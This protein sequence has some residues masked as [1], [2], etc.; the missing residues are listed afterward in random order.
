MVS[1]RCFLQ[2]SCP[3]L[4]GMGVTMGYSVVLADIEQLL[5]KS[6]PSCCRQQAFVGAFLVCACWHL[7][8]LPF[9]VRTKAT[10]GRSPQ[11]PSS[12]PEAP[13]WAAFFT[14]PSESSHICFVCPV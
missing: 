3:L 11:C 5:S 8:V 9:Q 6:C 10:V 14:L 13:H 1:C 2:M 7:Q 4:Y 12:G